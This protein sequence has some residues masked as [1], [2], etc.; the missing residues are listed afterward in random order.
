MTERI[1]KTIQTFH[2]LQECKGIII[3]VSGGSDSMC[4]LHYFIY[5]QAIPIAVAHINHGLRDEA[6]E[7]S[8]WLK[9]FAMHIMFHVFVI[10]RM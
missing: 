10:K 3:G 1:D 5:N 8:K 2:M 7:E 6:D 9:H 4:L